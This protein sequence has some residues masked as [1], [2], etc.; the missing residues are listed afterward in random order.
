MVIAFAIGFSF[1]SSS[2]TLADSGQP[3]TIRTMNIST[4]I[5]VGTSSVNILPASSS[6]VYAVFVND[7][8]NVI[9]LSFTSAN[10]V[11][12]QGIRL[13][14]NGGSYELNLSNDYIGNI[15]AIAAGAGSNLTVTA[16]Q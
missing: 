4:G 13:N 9:Y 12:G 10:A 14:A 8:S 1:L 7:S 6:R 3:N 5:S 2:K 16:S 11:S 15:N